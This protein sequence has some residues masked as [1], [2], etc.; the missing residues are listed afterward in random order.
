MVGG[1]SSESGWI[2]IRSTSL[3]SSSRASHSARIII[4]SGIEADEQRIRGMGHDFEWLLIDG[5]GGAAKAS[6]AARGT[7]PAAGGRGGDRRRCPTRSS[8][9]SGAGGPGE[10]GH[11]GGAW[12]ADRVQHLAHGHGGG[13]W[14][15]LTA[16][17]PRLGDGERGI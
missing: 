2:P 3:A 13:D 11:R 6:A 1:E 15:G 9:D 14:A 7:G 12:G 10:R 4:A 8:A 5:R 16:W 17:I